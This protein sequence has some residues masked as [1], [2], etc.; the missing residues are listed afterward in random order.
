[1]PIEDQANCRRLMATS[2]DRQPG[3]VRAAEASASEVMA[4]S[5]P[6]ANLSVG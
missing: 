3:L 6:W 5:L 1:M 2:L 4:S